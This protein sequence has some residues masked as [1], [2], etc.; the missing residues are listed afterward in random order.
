MDPSDIVE[1]EGRHNVG[2]GMHVRLEDNAYQL[3]ATLGCIQGG[4][5][6]ITRQG[7]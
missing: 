5:G 1:L 7:S 6:Q 4:G 3:Q 2:F